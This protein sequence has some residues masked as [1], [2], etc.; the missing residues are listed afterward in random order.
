[1]QHREMFIRVYLFPG[2]EEDSVRAYK[3]LEHL[4]DAHKDLFLTVYR[5][6]NRADG[7]WSLVLIGD[8]TSCARYQEQI[9]R[10]LREARAEQISVPTER[11]APLIERFLA[12]QAEMIRTKQTFLTRHD[13]L[14]YKEAKKVERSKKR[15]KKRGR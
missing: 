9:Q 10:P 12:R 13:P 15:K 4:I 8:D 1:M 7:R 11:L 2:E 14:A 3:T 5:G 6:L